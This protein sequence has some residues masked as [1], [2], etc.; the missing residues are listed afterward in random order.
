ML[1]NG[2]FYDGDRVAV[3]SLPLSLVERFG[4]TDSDTEDLSQL[5]PTIEGVDCAV[6]LKERSPN[7][8]KVSLRTG[9]RVNA[10]KVCAL[11]GG[12]GH[13]AA[14]GC[15]VS[16]VDEAAARDRVLDAIAAIVPDFNRNPE[17]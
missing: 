15:S 9:P 11:L 7:E 5:A 2:R 12:G 16:G 1:D 8:W 17:E 14:A 4:A 10:T 13:A 6:T 3:L